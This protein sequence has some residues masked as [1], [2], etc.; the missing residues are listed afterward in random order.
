MGAP[1]ILCGKTEQIGK[2]VIAGLK[3]QYDV[4]HFI[5]AAEAGAAE[6]PAILKGESPPCDSA[7]GRKDYSKPP[8]AVICG[9]GY[10]DAAIDVMMKASAGIKPILGFGPTWTSLRLRWGLNMARLWSHLDEEGKMDE[11]KVQWY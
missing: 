10:D 3:P 11:E 5:M 8:V 9:A 2:G 6:I 4:I 1:V 7:L